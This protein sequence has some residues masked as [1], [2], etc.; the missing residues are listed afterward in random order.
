[1]GPGRIH[2]VALSQPQLTCTVLR[3]LLWLGAGKVRP[4]F[5]GLSTAVPTLA[6]EPLLFTAMLVSASSGSLGFSALQRGSS[7]WAV[8]RR[9]R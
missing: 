8:G 2:Q 6:L 7:S 5:S 9:A 1:M 3:V 4:E